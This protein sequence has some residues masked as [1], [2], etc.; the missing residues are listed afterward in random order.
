MIDLD[1]LESYDLEDVDG[2]LT[3]K[4][5]MRVKFRLLGLFG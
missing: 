1:K 5:A 3:D 2:E 4:E